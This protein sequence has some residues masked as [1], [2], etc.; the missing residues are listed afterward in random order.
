MG[1]EI[2]KKYDNIDL[3]N[4]INLFWRHTKHFIR[5]LLLANEIV[6]SIVPGISDGMS[7]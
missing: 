5:L 6:V 1:F 3:D 4:E 7:H 2:Q